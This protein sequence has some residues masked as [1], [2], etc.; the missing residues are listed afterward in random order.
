[1]TVFNI[2]NEN[3]LDDWQLLEVTSKLVSRPVLE[4][5]TACED[6]NLSPT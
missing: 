5:Q 1:M 3:I 2:E 4:G 6:L